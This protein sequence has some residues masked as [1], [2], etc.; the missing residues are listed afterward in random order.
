MGCTQSNR[1]FVGAPRRD[2]LDLLTPESLRVKDSRR[3]KQEQILDYCMKAS[4]TTSSMAMVRERTEAA[5]A[6]MGSMRLT[7]SVG[8]ERQVGNLDSQQQ[9]SEPDQTVI[10]FDWD[11]TLCPSTCCRR[12]VRFDYKGKLLG[13]LST[14]NAE[15]LAQL[16]EQVIPLLKAAQTLGQVFLVTNARRPWVD[17]SCKNFM[18]TVQA[19]LKGIEII[20]AM[21]FLAE[22]ERADFAV[23]PGLLTESKARAMKAAISQHYSRYPNQSWK[24]IISVGDAL[25]EH[26]AIRQ[27]AKDRPSTRGLK[28][29]KKCRT[30]TVK[31]I[32]GPTLMG[33]NVQLNIIE[34]WLEKIVQCDDDVDIDLAADEE[35]VNAWMKQFG[36]EPEQED[37]DPTQV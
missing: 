32:E 33:L 18:P 23:N 24:N 27:V 19:H 28:P 35:T 5:Y 25:Y 29:A 11:D 4:S 15:V 1:D 31:L 12:H 34:S 20:Y 8:G 3:E 21:E 26:D 30:K 22:D 37:S 36:P 16:T 14:E 6:G 9:Y 7:D 2:G 13:K 17:T 10:I